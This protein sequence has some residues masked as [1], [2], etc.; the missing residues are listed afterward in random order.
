MAGRGPLLII[1]RDQALSCRIARLVRSYW[2]AV[3]VIST[4]EVFRILKEPPPPAGVVLD[5]DPDAGFGLDLLADLRRRDPSIPV[6]LL[7]RQEAAAQASAVALNLD[8][9]FLC[10]ESELSASLHRWMVLV[11][12]RIDAREAIAAV[13]QARRHLCHLPR[14]GAQVLQLVAEGLDQPAIASE[15]GLSADAVHDHSR[16]VLARLREHGHQADG[17]A[18]AALEV[19]HEA[20]ALSRLS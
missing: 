4:G 12:T 5:A 1:A 18:E 8:A 20:L 16:T 3:V 2:P 19:A 11:L 7:A 17:L 15:L 9:T 6:L 10:R 14:R 13:V